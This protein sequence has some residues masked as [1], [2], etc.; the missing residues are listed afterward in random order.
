MN[1]TDFDV[2]LELE[3][4]S[5]IKDFNSKYPLLTNGG[6]LEGTLQLE[7]STFTLLVKANI[8]SKRLYYDIEDSEGNKVTLN[9]PVVEYP[10]NLIHNDSMLG[11]ELYYVE[12]K[13]YFKSNKEE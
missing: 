7:N 10:Y 3:E 13:F 11:G 1:F 4:V 12:N 8:V 2:V 9:Q 5:T 6:I